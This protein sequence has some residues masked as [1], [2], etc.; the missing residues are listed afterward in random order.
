MTRED[1]FNW[2]RASTPWSRFPITD[3]PDEWRDELE[4]IW[5][6]HYDFIDNVLQSVSKIGEIWLPEAAMREHSSRLTVQ[7]QVAIYLRIR[8]YAPWRESEFRPGFERGFPG[9]VSSL[10]PMRTEEEQQRLWDERIADSEP[11]EIPY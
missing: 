9:C 8:D 7:E 5:R 11:N 4:E 10:P 2:A 3:I 1:F 6:D